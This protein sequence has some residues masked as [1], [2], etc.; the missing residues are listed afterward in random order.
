[1]RNKLKN[2]NA[3]LDKIANVTINVSYETNLIRNC[4]YHNPSYPN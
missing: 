3:P 2:L 4:R 1:M